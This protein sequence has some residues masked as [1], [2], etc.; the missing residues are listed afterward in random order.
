MI[1]FRMNAC[2]AARIAKQ[3]STYQAQMIENTKKHILNFILLTLLD[4]KSNFDINQIKTSCQ[5]GVRRAVS[6]PKMA[7]SYRLKSA[8]EA[9]GVFLHRTSV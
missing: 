1:R 9:V 6:V 8:K 7:Y 4:V 2:S 5:V 3:K